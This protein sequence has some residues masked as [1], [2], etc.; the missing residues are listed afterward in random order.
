[1]TTQHALPRAIITLM[2]GVVYRESDEETWSTIQRSLGPLLDHFAAIGVEIVVDDVEGYAYLRSRPTPDDE[3]PLPRLVH[4][5]SLSYPLSVLLVLLRK[6]LSEFEAADGA[7]K[8]VLS[9]AEITDMVRVF[10]AEST[11]EARLVDQVRTTIG[12]A[13]KLGFLA[14]VRGEPEHWEVRRILKAYVDAETLSDFDAKLRD[15]AAG[16]SGRSGDTD[17]T[18]QMAT[19]DGVSDE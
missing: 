6:R 16:R 4:R 13:V 1:M 18:I 2:N 12:Q 5:R 7:G 17:R 3:T 15:Y 10:T 14:T 8:L 9:T 19:T 11:N